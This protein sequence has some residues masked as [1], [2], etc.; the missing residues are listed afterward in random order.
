MKRRRRSYRKRDRQLLAAHARRLGGKQRKR[1]QR[2]KIAGAAFRQF[3]ITKGS[4]ASCG[5]APSKSRSHDYR[6]GGS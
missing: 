5:A 2:G 3:E 4:A 1:L 6:Y